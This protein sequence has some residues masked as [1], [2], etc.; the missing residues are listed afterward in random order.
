MKRSI[1]GR[2]WHGDG[3]ALVAL[4]NMLTEQERRRDSVPPDELQGALDVIT[5]YLQSGWGTGGGR[6]L[7]QFVWSLWNGHHLLNLFDLIPVPY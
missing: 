1:N 5:E 6:R 2:T 4:E 3:E 7:R